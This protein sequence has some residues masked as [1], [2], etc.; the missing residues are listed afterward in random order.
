MSKP[1]SVVQPDILQDNK[2]T[3]NS[4]L[5]QS[6]DHAKKHLGEGVNLIQDGVSFIKEEFSV[7]YHETGR[8]LHWMSLPVNN[9]LKDGVQIETEL[10]QEVSKDSPHYLLMNGEM[11]P[12]EQ[13]LSMPMEENH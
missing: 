3:I 11:V 9:F 12:V 7:F 1:T 2:M 4:Y 13:V 6:Y 10:L 5:K 8:C